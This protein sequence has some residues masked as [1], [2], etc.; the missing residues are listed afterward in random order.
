MVSPGRRAFSRAGSLFPILFIVP[1]AALVLAQSVDVSSR[2]ENFEKSRDYDALH[3]RLKFRFDERNKIYWAE[4][5]IT[6]AALADGLQKCMLDAEDF[7]V[8]SVVGQNE[9]PLK[10]KQTDKQPL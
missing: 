6:L 8:V 9:N 4:N 5:K 7:Q 10:Y 2:P 3:Y 1:I